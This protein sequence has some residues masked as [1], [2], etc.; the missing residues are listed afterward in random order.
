MD[1]G[2]IVTD[3]SR[4]D[5]CSTTA[6]AAAGADEQNPAGCGRIRSDGFAAHADRRSDL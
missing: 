6:A 4:D 2:Q 1:A 5:H 3:E